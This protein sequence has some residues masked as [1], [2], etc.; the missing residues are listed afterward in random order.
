MYLLVGLE[1]GLVPLAVLDVDFAVVVALLLFVCRHALL[2]WT[3]NKKTQPREKK[4][5]PTTI[6][7]NASCQ[8]SQHAQQ[9]ACAPQPDPSP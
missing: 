6:I 2:L 4:E 7:L 8:P 3:K 5:T 9:R 1:T